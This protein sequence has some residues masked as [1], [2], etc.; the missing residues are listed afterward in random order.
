MSDLSSIQEGLWFYI[1]HVFGSKDDNLI[2][3]GFPYFVMKSLNIRYA[4]FFQ[5]IR[6]FP[7][8]FLGKIYR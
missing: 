1:L 7:E 6:F 5:I 3:S 2:L 8:Y 4:S